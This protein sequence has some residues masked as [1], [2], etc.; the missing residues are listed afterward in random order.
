MLQKQSLSC[1][2]CFGTKVIKNGRKKSG[3]QNYRCQVCGKQFQDEY[4]YWGAEQKNKDLISRMLVKG[5]GIRDIANILTISTGCVLRVLL[6]YTNVELKPRHQ[7]YH[8]VQ[9]DE[10]YSFVQSKK[11]K[12]WILYA[13]CAQTKEILGLTMGKRN[14][15]TVKDLFKRLKNMN[16]NFWCTDA[17]KAFQ[18]V[19][20]AQKHLI[21]KRFT[22][23]I[24]GVNTSLR[25]ACKRLIRR[26]T[27]FSKKL[28][29]HWCAVKLVMYHTNLN[30]PYI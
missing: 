22:K 2:Y 30:S 17:W 18:E 8:Q 10:L 9:V 20:P 1:P 5:S 15:K 3:A 4:L 25:N 27:A 19:F 23:A 21:G 6:S 16:I 28:I 12:V 26:T 24:E 7:S 13:Y 14:R 29:N 11:K